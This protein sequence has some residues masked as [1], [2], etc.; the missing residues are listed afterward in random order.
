MLTFSDLP[1]RQTDVRTK[2]KNEPADMTTVEVSACRLDVENV[3][4]VEAS[5]S[6]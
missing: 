4:A 1:D 2:V 5:C 3:M 6:Q